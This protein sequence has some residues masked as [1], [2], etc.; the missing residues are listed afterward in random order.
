MELTGRPGGPPTWPAADI[1]GPLTSLGRRVAA[2]SSAVGARVEVDIPELLSGRAALLG[3]TRCGDRSA[4]GSA[5]LLRTLDGWV[6]LNLARAADLESLPALLAM[7]GAPDAPLEGALREVASHRVVEAGQLLGLALSS[8]VSPVGGRVR[9]G[10]P[11]VPQGAVGARRWAKTALRARGTT[12]SSP[13]V[14]DLSSL[15]AGPLCAQI[16]RRAGCRVRKVESTSRPD[17]AR[18]GDPRVWRWL[19]ESD[20]STVVDFASLAG[21]RQLAGLLES[22]D[23]IIEGS[24]GRA[25][26]QLGLGPTQVT[27]RPGAVWVSVTGYGRGSNRVAFGDDAAVAGGLVAWDDVGPMFCGDALGDPVAG[28]TA[29]VAALE[30][31]ADGGGVHLDL[32]MAAAVAAVADPSGDARPAGAASAERDLGTHRVRRR[33]DGRWELS[34]GERWV[35]V[36]SPVLPG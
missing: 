23:V 2:A 31:L 3:L 10:G 24:R 11:G 32:S 16:L 25:L 20:E 13:L 17:G 29:A 22:A 33:P 18:L 27:P 28:L 34:C 8:A 6:A 7:L 5:H 30:A 9:E 14:V 19:H 1:G 15:W 12:H 36:V 4:G 21:R 26:D 35:S